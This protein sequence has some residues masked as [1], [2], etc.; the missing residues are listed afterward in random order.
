MKKV[1]IFAGRGAG[2]YRDPWEIRKFLSMKNTNMRRVAQHLGVKYPQVQETV[3]GI[4][5]DR[6]VLAYLRDMGCPQDALSLPED[7]EQKV[8]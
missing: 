6:T 1:N 8:V 4:R 3:R 2:I 5:N 7:M